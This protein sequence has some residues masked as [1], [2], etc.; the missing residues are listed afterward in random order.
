MLCQVKKYG[1]RCSLAR[2]LDVVGERWSLLV[3]RELTIGPRRYSDLLDGLPGI[4]TNL[5]ATRLKDLQATGIISKR[6]LPPPTAVTVYE[7]T[8]AG[9]ALRPALNELRDWGARFG[10]APSGTDAIRPAWPLLSAAAR[11]TALPEGRVCEL[12]V[13]IEFFQ[14]SATQSRLSVHGGPAQAADSTIIMSADTLYNLATASIT[15]AATTR[16]TTITGDAGIAQSALE[17][18]H[19][20]LTVPPSG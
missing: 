19:G 16:Q 20:V 7:L 12:R 9:H 4:P 8:D 1:Q 14:L 5:L 17:S 18:L 15:T 3:V 11:P 10:T 6:T 2:A 13:G